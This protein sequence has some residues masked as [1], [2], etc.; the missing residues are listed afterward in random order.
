MPRFIIAIDVDGD[1]HRFISSADSL[2]QLIERISS[3]ESD[4]YKPHRIVEIPE[5][6]ELLHKAIS[7]QLE[8]WDALRDLERYY[9][10]SGDGDELHDVHDW[11]DHVCVGLDSPVDITDHERM[12]AL[13]NDLLEDSGLEKCDFS[14]FIHHPE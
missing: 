7:R 8:L 2:E 11:M 6:V 12:F 9:E 10:D 1:E 14:R 5:P 4:I 3:K 13:M